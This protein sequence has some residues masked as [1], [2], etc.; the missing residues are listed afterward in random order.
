MINMLHTALK[1]D[2]LP[3]TAHLECA[4]GRTDS[5]LQTYSG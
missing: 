3:R 4:H 2:Q 5:M 1:Y